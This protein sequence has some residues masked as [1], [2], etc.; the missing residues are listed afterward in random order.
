MTTSSKNRNRATSRIIKKH[1]P[2][3]VMCSVAACRLTRFGLRVLHRGGTTLPGRSAMFFDKDILEVVSRGM[4]I[5]V[6]TGTNGKTTTCS[7]LRN[8][9]QE[10]GIEPL[11]NISGANLLTGITAEFTASA[12]L[13]GKPHKRFAIVE[14]DEGALKK[15]VPLIRPKV[16]VVTNLFRD[17]LDR[18]G[19]VM[20]TLEEI[21]TGIKLVPETTLCLNADCS[22]TASLAG[23][24]EA[25]PNPVYYYGIEGSAAQ[26]KLNVSE[27]ELSDAKYCIKCGNEYSYDYHTYAHLGGY[28]CPKCGYKRMIPNLQVES[29]DKMNSQGSDIKVSFNNIDRPSTPNKRSSETKKIHVGLPALYNIYNSIAAIGAFEAAGWK[30]TSITQSLA[31]ISSSFGRM[32]SFNYNNVDIQMILV[33][34]PAGCNQSLTYLSSLDEDYVAVFCLNDKTADGHDISWIWDAEHEK[35]AQD[36]H[37]KFIYISGTRAGDMSIRLKYAGASTQRLIIIED[38]KELLEKMTSHSLPVYVLPNY[39]SMLSL[40]AVVGAATGK[41]EFWKDQK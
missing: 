14:C 40:R 29:I 16:I 10:A 20:H 31:N 12:S 28:V 7:M 18:Y 13:T 36:P 9:L 35:V 22:L 34:N 37:C 19:E 8:A 33:K 17:Q 27:N 24:D 5:V 26:G 11:S 39:T 15:V 21:R 2:I 6:V 1:N 3:K 41:K 23:I 30:R 4:E 38:N 32:E 25:L